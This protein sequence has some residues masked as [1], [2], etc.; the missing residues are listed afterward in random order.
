VTQAGAL[1]ALLLLAGPAP[2]AADDAAEARFHDSLAREHYSSR[3]Y[4][5][6]IREFML[7][8]RLA[9]NP[10]LLFNIALCFEQLDRPAEAFAYYTEYERAGEDA[11]ERRA[12]A[13]T[14]LVR[15]RPRLALVDVVSEPPGGR[16]YVDEPDVG[17]YGET[18]RVLALPPG[19]RRILVERDGHHRGEATVEARTGSEEQ[20]VVRLEPIVGTLRVTAA[21]PASVRVLTLEGV[22]VAEGETPFEARV[23]PGHYQVVAVAEGR[24]PFRDPVVE[25]PRDAVVERRAALVRP[26]RGTGEMTVTASAPGATVE[27]DGEALGFAPLLLPQ[28]TAGRHRIRLRHPDLRP[29]SGTVVLEPDERLFV[30]VGLGR[31]DA[32]QPTPAT[33]ALGGVGATML[34]SAAFT[35]AFAVVNR[36]NAVDGASSRGSGDLA[37]L[38]ILRDRARLLNVTTDALLLAGTSLLVTAIVLYFTTREPGARESRAFITRGER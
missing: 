27:V 14:A 26:P 6:A 20:V 12:A 8:N 7:A 24:V 19:T 34:L 33:W 9:P 22:V 16:I 37:Q 35:G 18:P 25:V 32:G 2:A 17:S 29:W 4:E 13:T 36:N 31:P 30:T 28:V 1:V 5:L 15:L 3:R 11:P 23:P 10:R 38:E 21:I